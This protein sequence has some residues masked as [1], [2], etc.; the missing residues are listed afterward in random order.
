MTKTHLS[1]LDSSLINHI[2]V[3]LL[4]QARKGPC[5]LPAYALCK[6]KWYFASVLSFGSTITYHISSSA[7]RMGCFHVWQVRTDR[8]FLATFVSQVK[9]MFLEERL[10][11]DTPLAFVS[12]TEISGI[13][14]WVRNHCCPSDFRSKNRPM[15]NPCLLSLSTMT[16]FWYY[17]S[18][19]Q[20]WVLQYRGNNYILQRILKR[21]TKI[22]KGLEYSHKERLRK[23]G[24]WNLKRRPRRDLI[25][26][27]EYLNGG[28]KSN[29]VRLWCPVGRPEA[30]GRNRNTGSSLLTS[31]KRF[32]LKSLLINQRS[33]EQFL[34][35]V[36][37]SGETP[38]ALI[39]LQV[40]FCHV[41]RYFCFSVSKT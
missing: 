17:T 10:P 2:R 24:L 30:R 29:R 11:H 9:K 34:T 19:V 35:F 32:L 5:S 12:E 14:F 13:L 41:L 6:L 28:C 15:T 21:A 16:I 22:T 36:E 18:W 31:E 27:Y 20:F 8:N 38:P 40:S 23:L 26:P 1:C 7:V 4:P 33:S 3:A 37:N 39:R 25:N